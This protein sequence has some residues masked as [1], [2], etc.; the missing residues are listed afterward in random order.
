MDRRVV[1][2]GMG[3]ISPLGLSVAELWQG[4]VAARSGVGPITLFD[5]TGF[6]TR[7]AAEVKGFDP[8]NYM[9]RKEARRT[10][11]FVQFAIAATKEALRDAE[12]EITPANRDEI[13]VFIASGIGGIATLSE[14]LEVLR[15]R[16]P[17]RIS[18][19]LIPAMITNL[20]AGQVS[21]VTGARG[22][23]YCVTSACAS[24][25]HAIGEAAETIRRGWAKAMIVG[26]SEASIT[27]IGVAGFNAMRALSTRNE[28]YDHASRP[29]DAERDG[30]VMGEGAAVLILEDLE[31]ALARGARILAEVVGYGATSDAYH[32]SNLAEDGEGVARAIRLA[33]QRG[34]LTPGDVD[35]INAHATSTPSGDPVETAAI[36]Q[37]FGGREQSPPVSASKSQFGHLL[38]AAGAIEAVVTVLAMQNNLLPATINLQHPDPACDLDFVPNHPRPAQIEVA[39]SNSFGFGGHNVCLAFRKYHG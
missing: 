17:G 25:A 4:I 38:G 27:P 8:I 24:S 39:L 9:D 22:P 36:K 5:P 19:F 11:R 6:D 18:P 16:G 28:D 32:I 30:F 2:T 1:V 7:F 21:I 12:L 14:Q 20:A 23:S 15:S 29:F 10:D 3:A 35:Y 37:V 13:G 34:G 31:F 26:G 33:L